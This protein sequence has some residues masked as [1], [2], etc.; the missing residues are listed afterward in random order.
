[1]VSLVKVKLFLTKWRERILL[2]NQKKKKKMN[3]FEI[4]N[5]CLS[6]VKQTSSKSGLRKWRKYDETSKRYREI[7]LFKCQLKGSFPIIICLT[8]NK[9][10]MTCIVKII[11]VKILRWFESLNQWSNKKPRKRLV[12]S[13]QTIYEFFDIAILD[14]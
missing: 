3:P 4:M 11:F 7:R 10:Y 6:L 14:R 5:K 8:D 9:L 12:D 2:L 13:S 1:M